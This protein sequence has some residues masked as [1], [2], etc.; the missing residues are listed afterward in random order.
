MSRGRCSSKVTQFKGFLD[1]I[2]H[3][4]IC[5]YIQDKNS[6]NLITKKYIHL[7]LTNPITR[8]N[9]NYM[10]KIISTNGDCQ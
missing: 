4:N 3:I 10:L 7:R 2:I 1:Y 6:I 9:K 5:H 8:N